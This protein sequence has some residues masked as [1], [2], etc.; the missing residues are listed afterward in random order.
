M[1]ISEAK[2]VA[3]MFIIYPLNISIYYSSLDCLFKTFT[4]WQLNNLF[5]TK[6]ESNV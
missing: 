5:W 6:A 1:Q 2:I 4:S 3:I